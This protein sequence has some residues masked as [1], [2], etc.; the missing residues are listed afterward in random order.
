MI[1]TRKRNVKNIKCAYILAWPAYP[2]FVRIHFK[3]FV[4]SVFTESE[5]AR[6]GD[7]NSLGN[8]LFEVSFFKS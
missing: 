2:I 7:K 5:H 3:S 6:F 4:T 8:E 1:F